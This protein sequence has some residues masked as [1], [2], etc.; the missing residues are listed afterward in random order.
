MLKRSLIIEILFF[1]EKGQ[2][3]YIKFSAFPPKRYDVIYGTVMNVGVT[4]RHEQEINGVYA[5]LIKI[6]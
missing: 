6:D 3:A 2:H 1:L 5:V 4:T